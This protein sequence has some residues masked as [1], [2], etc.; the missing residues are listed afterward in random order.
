M[1]L[2]VTEYSVHCR[3]RYWED[4]SDQIKHQSWI[5]KSYK[6]YFNICTYVLETKKNLL[7]FSA[8]NFVGFIPIFVA[9]ATV[10]LI[11]LHVI[12]LRSLKTFLRKPGPH[13]SNYHDRP[14]HIFWRMVRF[15]KICL[16]L[17]IKLKL[18]NYPKLYLMSVRLWNFKDGGS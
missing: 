12:Q 7:S 6:K 18:K 3:Y 2:K 5:Y 13:S 11:V 1:E 17:V 15:L 4:L 8:C 16:R 9:V 10:V 14:T